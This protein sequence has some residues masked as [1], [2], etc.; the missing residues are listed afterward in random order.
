R[1]HH[2]PAGE[3]PLDV[4]VAAPCVDE[5]VV[6][7]DDAGVEVE[8]DPP[9]PA[10]RAG[11]EHLGVLHRFG[12]Y[13]IVREVGD[14]RHDGGRVGVDGDRLRRLVGHGWQATGLDTG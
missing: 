8:R 6:V 3:V 14:H 9:G 7:A 10:V 2:L 11:L 1:A 13:R 4:L 12:P 5:F